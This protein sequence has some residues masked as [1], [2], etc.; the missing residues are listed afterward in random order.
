MT[1][2][3]IVFCRKNKKLWIRQVI[4]PNINDDEAHAIKLREFAETI[5]NVERVELLP[6]HSM[7]KSKYEELNIPYRLKDTPDMDKERCKNLENILKNNKK[8]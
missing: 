1:I 8:K 6:Y 3:Q 2:N 5:P 4:V 7:A